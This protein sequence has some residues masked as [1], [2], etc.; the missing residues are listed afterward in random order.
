MAYLSPDFD[1]DLFISYPHGD[2]DQVGSSR[3]KT[4]S[5]IFVAEFVDELRLSLEGEQLVV[6]RDEDKRSGFGIDPTREL[7]EQLQQA[8]QTSGLLVVLMSPFYLKSD[9]CKQEANWF[10][11][12]AER[13][14]RGNGFIFVARIW[15][16]KAEDWPPELKGALGF[17]FFDR[18]IGRERPNRV[19]PFGWADP[20][21]HDHD[22]TFRK[23][24]GDLVEPAAERL[25]EM[26]ERWEEGRREAAAQRRLAEPS[27]QILY[28]YARSTHRRLWERARDEL[29]QAGFAV[30]PSE[31][32]PDPE[33]GPEAEAKAAG[34][35]IGLLK[36]CDALV[37]LRPQPGDYFYTDLADVGVRDRRN[38]RED[39]GGPMPCAVVDFTGVADHNDRQRRFAQNSQIEWIEGWQ[40]GWPAKVLTPR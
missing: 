9:W 32:D 40:P 15:P 29:V 7:P 1:Y 13:R 17:W 6:F 4:W 21:Q 2:F 14:Q 36:Q 18:K 3:L 24:L 28:L 25:K 23:A 38:A 8:V 33:Q 37:L 31:P 11:A 22:G 26:R 35:R 27:G 20:I 30:R 10:V 34:Q 19:R 12:E 5:Q 39:G 16:T